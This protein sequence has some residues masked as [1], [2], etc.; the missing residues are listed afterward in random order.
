[1]RG[2]HHEEVVHRGKNVAN[3][4]R[5]A[6]PGIAKYLTLM[7]LYGQVNVTAD[8]DFQR[9]YN[10]FYKMRQRTPAY[11]QAYYQLMERLRGTKPSFATVIDALYTATGRFEPSFSSKMVAT[12][13][14]HKPV[15]DK[16]VLQNLGLKAPNSNSKTR[17]ANLKKCYS[18]IEDWYRHFLGTNEARGW[19]EQF[20]NEVED[21]A[22]LSQLKKI[23]F[24]LWQT[25]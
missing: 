15:W 12:L 1:M 5:K 24:I 23:D 3:A 25:R 11:Y 22:N 14:P 18:A 17:L 6:K 2:L 21:H 10:G 4:I 19:I 20:D 13:D 7:N 16:Y 9:Q 8:T